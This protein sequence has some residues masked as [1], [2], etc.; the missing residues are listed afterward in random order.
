MNEDNQVAVD[1]AE[2]T[3]GS[4]VVELDR[5]TVFEVTGE[6]RRKFLHSFCTAEIEKLDDGKATEAFILNDKGKIIGF[7][8]V[9]AL[10]HRLLVVTSKDQFQTLFTHLDRYNFHSD[11]EISEWSGDFVCY[12]AAGNGVDAKIVDW[13]G[14]TIERNCV[15]EFDVG[16]NELIVGH[17][18]LA[19]FGYLLAF[20][21]PPDDS[22]I[23]DRGFS[24]CSLESMTVLRVAH[25]TP[26]FGIDITDENLPQ[27]IARDALAISFDK[28][29]YLGQET[30]ARIDAMG[31]VNQLLIPL[32]LTEEAVFG[33]LLT[34]D[35]KKAGK[36][37]TVTRSPL[38]QK[39]VALGLVRRNL[40]DC[41]LQYDGPKGPGVAR[42]PAKPND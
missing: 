28:G 29:C 8:H 26:V 15:G 13:F 11:V 38:R 5:P 16:D 30:V 14:T 24:K 19:G 7:V 31:R 20:K 33:A 18:E 1:F 22:W 42:K 34:V 21:S 35:S 32:E 4:G 17:V 37:T 39:W 25:A 36:L 9:L 41:E 6:A 40:L 10:A 23:G 2:L 12:F 3:N 27:E